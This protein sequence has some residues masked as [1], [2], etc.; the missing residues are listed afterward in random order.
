MSA[1]VVQNDAIATAYLRKA[2]Q[3]YPARTSEPSL[4]HAFET[5]LRSLPPSSLVP[6]L[7]LKQLADALHSHQAGA[8]YPS[9]EWQ[10][11]MGMLASYLLLISFQ[12][13][14]PG[15]TLASVCV[16]CDISVLYLETVHPVYI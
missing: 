2:L 4:V 8:A 1:V 14:S 16:C 5:M 7:I 13:C 3:L 6:L 15:P 9:M 10:A 11:L 12:V